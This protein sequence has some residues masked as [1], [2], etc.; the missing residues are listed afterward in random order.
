MEDVAAASNQIEESL[1]KRLKLK[2]D[3]IGQLATGIRKIAASK[4]PIGNLISRTKI[5]KGLVLDKV[6]VP[7]GVLLI[8]FEARPDALPQIAAL[9]IRSGNGLLLKGGKEAANSNTFLHKIIGDAIDEVAPGV[10]RSVI[11]LVQTRAAI[12][13]LLKL[14]DVIDLVI[15]RGSNKFVSYIQ[16][17]TKIP[18]LGHSDGICHVY[19]DEDADLAMAVN[20][21]T[22]AK[23]DY[24]AACNAV[25][26]I[27]V[28]KS[29][30][31]S[32]GVR[33]LTEA[34]ADAGGEF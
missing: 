6:T 29:W 19:V 33:T 21:C 32:G 14:E 34:L 17:N 7:I 20:V 24:A 8:I 13:E 26:K 12:S 9:A 27:L 11:G 28:H 16:D 4:E 31:R 3:K 23:T 5:M 18:V 10:G 2:P 15:P 30:V 1:M 25:E 22:D